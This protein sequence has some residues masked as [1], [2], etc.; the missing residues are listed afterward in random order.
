MAPTSDLKKLKVFYLF[1]IQCFFVI[2]VL[3]E[4]HF[5]K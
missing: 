5:V 1:L 3:N 2:L 4:F